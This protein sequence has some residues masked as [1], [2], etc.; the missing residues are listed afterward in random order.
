MKIRIYKPLVACEEFYRS[1]WFK[2]RP[3][4]IQKL[5]R[6]YPIFTRLNIDSIK[7]YLVGIDESKKKGNEMLIISKYNPLTD[8]QLAVNNK[9]KIHIKHLKQ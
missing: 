2:S 1:S 6:K 9:V 7:Y 5:F 4:H 8:Y 3:K